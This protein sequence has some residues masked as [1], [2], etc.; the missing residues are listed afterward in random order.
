MD[1]TPFL[2]Y[3]ETIDLQQNRMLSLV[4]TW[5]NINTGTDNLQGLN[6]MISSLERTFCSLEGNMLKIPLPPRKKI[7][8]EGR[9]TTVPCGQAL[10]IIKRPEAPVRVFLGGHMDTVF[11][12]SDPFQ[13]TEMI[14]NI[15]L[16]GPGVTDMKGGLA[17]ILIALETLEKTPFAEGIG[18]EVLINSDEENGSQSSKALLELAAKRNHIGLLFEPALPDGSIVSSRKGSLNASIIVRGK[19]AH[20][21]REYHLGRNAIHSLAKVV[22][23]LSL[24]N[25]E[26]SGIICNVG[27]VSG[28]GA[29][30]IVPDFA[31]CRVNLRVNTLNQ[32]DHIQ[33]VI[34]KI[35]KEIQYSDQTVIEFFEESKRP[36]KFFDGQTEKIF[37]RMRECAQ[38]LGKELQW[39][40]S[41]GVCDGNNLAAAGMPTIDTL[42][43]VGSHIHT[44]EEHLFIGS[45]TERA[46]LTALFLMQLA[47]QGGIL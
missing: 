3:L 16:R 20:A 5:A 37:K 44:N 38:L 33:Q 34:Q 42:G 14:D 1:I 26:T 2:P 21:G 22:C 6:E 25:D 23:G 12:A 40:E 10:S 45:L 29:V 13:R 47:V 7:D 46:R 35:I 11:P 8:L 36:P 24:L 19:T 30:N 15:T 39:H 17:I 32:M 18:W 27:Y 9:V 4:K 43:V 28:G 41:G 31:L